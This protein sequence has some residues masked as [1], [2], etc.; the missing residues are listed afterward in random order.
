MSDWTETFRPDLDAAFSWLAAHALTAAALAVAVALAARLVRHAVVVHALWVVVLLKLLLPPFIEVGIL[1]APEAMPSVDETAGTA[2]AADR[3]ATVAAVESRAFGAETAER[4]GSGS[5]TAG[6]LGVFA[7][8][9]L[10]LAVLALTRIRRFRRRLEASAAPPEALSA[11]VAELCRRL[12]LSR[13][14]GVRVVASRVSPMIWPRLAG[15]E[16]ILP[17]ALLGR[18]S[19]GELDAVLGH[20]LAHLRRRDHWV[21]LLELAAT[22]LFWWHPAVWWARRRLRREEERCCDAWVAH[23]LPGRSRDYA[24]GLLKTLEFLAGAE[25]PLAAVATGIGRARTD[26]K[27]RLTMILTERTPRLLSSRHRFAIAAVAVALLAVLPTRAGRAGG[28][29]EDKESRGAEET[30]LRE[31]ALDLERREVD[32][33]RQLHELEIERRDLAR[34]RAAAES[35]AELARLERQARELEASGKTEEAERVRGRRAEIEREADLS[36]EQWELER[37]LVEER[38]PEE[39]ALREKMLEIEKLELAGDHAEA[40]ALRAEA[41]A[42]KERLAAAAME[43]DQRRREIEK[44]RLAARLEALESRRSALSDA[45]SESEAA[46]LA[47]EMARLEAET[48]LAKARS[49]QEAQEGQLRRL[50]EISAKIGALEAAG[51]VEAAEEL[52]RQ[53]TARSL[54]MHV[55]RSHLEAELQERLRVLERELA[56]ESA[57]KKKRSSDEAAKEKAAKEKAAKD[58]AAKEKAAKE[59]NKEKETKSEDRRER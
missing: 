22:V 52:R 38:M 32:L 16:L 48:A 35:E 40:E 34:Q 7:A 41:R 9:S 24:E 20:E 14:P 15:A 6:V 18:L 45:S 28:E 50:L 13:P 3:P 10:S 17:E 27:E 12:G 26:M 29:G 33:R 4:R 57:V 36:R 55:K 44:A 1:P 43:L 5:W 53:L 54:E 11:R 46:R 59:K 39:L 47:E 2:R 37:R 49:A 21:R 58:K 23:A 31:Q 25:R 42:G 8:G 56:E 51:D 30:R 19:G